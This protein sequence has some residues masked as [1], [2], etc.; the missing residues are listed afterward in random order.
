[1]RSIILSSC[2][3]GLSCTTGV[4][5]N[6]DIK[7]GEVPTED[8]AEAKDSGEPA[9]TDDTDD[10]DEEQTKLWNFSGDFS[11][12]SEGREPF[13]S[14]EMAG[15]LE[16]DQFFVSEGYCTIE[17]GPNRGDTLGFA[18][19]GDFDG[20]KFDGMTY[21]MNQDGQIFFQ[22]EGTYDADNGTMEFEWTI[23]V[24]GPDGSQIELIGLADLEK[25]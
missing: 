22:T 8:T 21:L 6:L 17:Q 11:L 1:M 10:T 14:D 24:T 7:E 5:L 15:V 23:H 12:G 18:I 3:L 13:C 20:E 9:D 2:W 16:V 4:T 25:D 19:K